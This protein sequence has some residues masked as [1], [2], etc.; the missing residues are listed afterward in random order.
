VADGRQELIRELFDR[1]N[2]GIRELRLSEISP[3]AIVKSTLTGA[4]YKGHDGI[5]EWMAEIDDQF[6]DWNVTIEEMQDVPPD[7]VL[8]IGNVH[9]R[10]RGSGVEF[11]QPIAWICRF[12]DD[13]VTEM[14]NYSDQSAARDAAKASSP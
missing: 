5:R 10:G 9:F 3:D 14:H 2:R 12:S 13:R 11:D 1:W 6:D 4:T 7:R 8:A